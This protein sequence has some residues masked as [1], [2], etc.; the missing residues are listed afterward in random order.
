[1]NYSLWSFSAT[2]VKMTKNVSTCNWLVLIIRCYAIR[3]WIRSMEHLDLLSY[4]FLF[5]V[6]CLPFIHNVVLTLCAPVANHD[7]PYHYRPQKQ[8]RPGSGRLRGSTPGGGR[9]SAAGGDA[10]ILPLSAEEARM[11]RR[12]KEEHA[13]RGGWVRI[14]PTPESWDLY[15]LVIVIVMANS[16]LSIGCVAA[17]PEFPM[18][19]Y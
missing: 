19:N 14:F 15:R 3:L 11:V 17:P 7:N 6:M 2:E 16:K 12:V 8:I 13:R 4:L 18:C 5:D 10:G 9:G 1:M